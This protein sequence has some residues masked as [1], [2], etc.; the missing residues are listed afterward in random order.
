LPPEKLFPEFKSTLWKEAQTLDILRS[1]DQARTSFVMMTDK[2]GEL[3]AKIVVIGCG[4]TS[5]VGF[6]SRL[7][8][9]LAT[10]SPSDLAIHGDDLWQIAAFHVRTEAAGCPRRVCTIPDIDCSS[11]DSC[12]D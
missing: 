8:N 5:P 2:A 10:C 9:E 7:H 3:M 12:M 4:G 1:H 11:R 6:V